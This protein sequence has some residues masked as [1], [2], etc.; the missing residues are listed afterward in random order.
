MEK[1]PLKNKI[2]KRTYIQVEGELTSPLLAGSGEDDFSDMDILRD[3]KGTPFLAGTAVAGACRQWLHA[4]SMDETAIDSLFGARKKEEIKQDSDLFQSRIFISDLQFKDPQITIRDHVKLTENKIADNMGK[5]D[6]EVIETGTPFI[7]RFEYIEREST[8]GHHDDTLIRAIVSAINHGELTFGGKT[9]RGYGKLKVKEVKQKEF[10][11][12]DTTTV[13]EWLKWSWEKI[14]KEKSSLNNYIKIEKQFH[15]V[16]VPLKIKQTLLIRDYKTNENDYTYLRANNKPVIPGTTW[17]GAFRHRLKQIAREIIGDLEV[18]E[19]IE[20][21]F[22][23]KHDKKQT[24][25]SR[26][27]FEE[28]VIEEATP[29]KITRNAI[30][31]FSGATIHGA[32]FTGESVCKGKT[33]LVIRWRKDSCYDPIIKGILHWLIQDLMHGFLAIGGEIAVGRGVFEM[34]G[35]NDPVK[36]WRIYQKSA[37]TW[38]KDGVKHETSTV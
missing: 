21:I 13:K 9:N 15:E 24:N 34:D 10:L 27:T 3:Y 37:L 26:L 25:P 17:A 30:D 35:E 22:G 31:R 1:K 2:T 14:Y 11:Y 23:S 7:M 18:S 20:E 28:S 6:V 19:K 16:I 4:N 33:S 8:G 38:I 36:D 12:T 5:F 29:F 32:L